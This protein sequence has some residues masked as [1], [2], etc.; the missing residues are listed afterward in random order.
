ME[1]GLYYGWDG[2]S[3]LNLQSTELETDIFLQSVT[4]SALIPW[5]ATQIEHNNS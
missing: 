3:S 4:G 2:V 1:D 5:S